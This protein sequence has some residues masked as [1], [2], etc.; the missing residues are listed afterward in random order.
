MPDFEY[1]YARADIGAAPV[2]KVGRKTH[3]CAPEN[4]SRVIVV[5]VVV[6]VD[7]IVFPTPSVTRQHSPLWEIPSV[8]RQH[9]LL[10]EV[11]SVT[12]PTVGGITVV[13]QQNR[14]KH[15]LRRP[16]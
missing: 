9:N 8:T 12:Q 13:R 4:Y 5:V 3:C 16:V 14:T 1:V 2:N 11:P 15:P 10:W 7:V 6:V